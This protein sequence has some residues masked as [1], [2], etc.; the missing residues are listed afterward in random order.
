[1]KTSITTILLSSIC[2]AAIY[3]TACQ[4]TDK[5]A[6]QVT[7]N[8][9]VTNDSTTTTVS[10]KHAKGFQVA[11]FPNY[12]VVTIFPAREASQENAT[13]YIL[14]P[15]GTTVPVD[16]PE[17]TVIEVP[18][19]KM[20][21][22][23]SLHIGM[24]ALLGAVENVVGVDQ[25]AYVYSPEIHR[26]AKEGKVVE[27]GQSM[28]PNLE[29]IVALQPDLVMGTGN[30]GPSPLQQVQEA[31]IPV[32][33]NSE[34]MEQTPLGK[35][36][37]VKLMAVLLGK[38]ELVNKRF[39]EIEKEYNRLASMTKSL[40]QLPSV[41]TGINLKD[42]WYM[43]N[44]DNYMAQFLTDAGADYPLKNRPGSGSSAL[45]FEAIYPMALQAPIWLN[46]GGIEV[47]AKNDLLVLDARYADFK[48]FKDGAIFD[49]SSRINEVGANDFWES[50]GVRPDIVLADLIKMLHPTLLPEHEL[51]YYKPIR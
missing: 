11:T 5:T 2:L 20:V 32:I 46:L 30:S 1:M 31:G 23:S 43:P 37:W 21:A 18:I 42:V 3:L 45:T 35:A 40:S 9:I 12:K 26:M 10:I 25:L 24:L 39:E 49:Y 47:R 48:S 19:R 38:E 27:V 8:A 13:N 14:V 33:L 16:A 28:S 41:I 7:N 51:Y 29:T 34:W 6:K 17:G 22:M 36:E 44:R 15:R 50:A 4:T